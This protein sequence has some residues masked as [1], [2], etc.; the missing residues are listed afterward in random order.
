[1]KKQLREFDKAWANASRYGVGVFITMTMNP[2]SYSN[3]VEAD[4]MMDRASN[5]FNS[6]MRRRHG[7]K[8]SFTRIP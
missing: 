2:R 6:F 1:L 7:K 3:L 8:I 5:R 4:E